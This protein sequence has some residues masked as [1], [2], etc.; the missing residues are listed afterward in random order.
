MDV[1][2]QAHLDRFVPAGG[3]SLHLL[4][5]SSTLTTLLKEGCG[6]SSETAHLWALASSPSPYTGV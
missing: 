6:S 4:L 2:A 1:H 3:N 5:D